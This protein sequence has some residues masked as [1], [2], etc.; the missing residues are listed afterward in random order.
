MEV[1]LPEKYLS[2]GYLELIQEL[3]SAGADTTTAEV[4]L[5]SLD[6]QL[7]ERKIFQVPPRK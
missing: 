4:G 2:R 1:Q 5:Y 7:E 3:V 6:P